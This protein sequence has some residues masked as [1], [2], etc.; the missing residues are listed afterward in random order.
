MVLE[1]LEELLGELPSLLLWEEGVLLE[2]Q[3]PV[4]DIFPPLPSQSGNLIP[5]CLG[6]TRWS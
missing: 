1:E 5:L 6:P 2:Q 3:Y 4:K